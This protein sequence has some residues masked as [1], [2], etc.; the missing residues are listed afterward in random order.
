MGDSDRS[1]FGEDGTEEKGRET[2]T[3]RGMRRGGRG[4]RRRI[5]GGG[6]EEEEGEEGKECY[7]RDGSTAAEAL[8]TE[9][10]VSPWRSEL[11]GWAT[12]R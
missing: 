2:R 9:R 1:V 7:S 5:G 12:F 3:G 6:G 11:G 8:F 4:K 10:P